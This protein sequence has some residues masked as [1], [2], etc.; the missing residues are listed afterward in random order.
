VQRKQDEGRSRE[1]TVVKR[2]KRGE[3]GWGGG[4]KSQN[5]SIGQLVFL[6]G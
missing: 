5:T 2:R 1:E 4:I 3:K 6:F